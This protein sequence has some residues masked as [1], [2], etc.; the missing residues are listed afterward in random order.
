MLKKLTFCPCP[1]LSFYVGV[2]VRG[3]G[4]VVDQT[5]KKNKQSQIVIS[6]AKKIQQEE[7]W[8]VR[9]QR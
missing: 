4:M 9:L 8:G 2:G 7:G 3:S 6:A 5:I 1:L